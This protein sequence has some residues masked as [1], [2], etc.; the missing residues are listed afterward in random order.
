MSA[1]DQESVEAFA[2]RARAWLAEH[3]PRG[4]ASRVYHA[5]LSDEEVVAAIARGRELQRIL[6]DGGFAGICFPEGYGGLGLTPAH[7]Q[8]FTA[9]CAGYEMPL[10][11]N[12]PTFVPCG[13]ILVEFGTDEQKHRCLPA[14]LKGEALW[15]QFLSEPSGG[16]DVAGALTSAVRDGDEWV[17]NGSK[18]WTTGAWWSDYALCL[19]RT[20]WDVPKHRGLTVFIVEIRQPSVD[21]HRIQMIYGSRDFCQEFMTDLRVPDCDRVG[22]VDDG[23]T[24]CT[25]WMFHERNAVSGGSPYVSGGLASD[26]DDI[27]T[28]QLV[29][30]ARMTGRHDDAWT[31]DRIGEA[32]MLEHAHAALTRRIGEGLTD[33]AFPDAAA[34]IARLSSAVV[35]QRITT[36]GLELAGNAGAHSGYGMEYLMRQTASIGGGTSE[37]ARNNISE[38]VLGMPRE[39]TLDRETAFR[40]VPRG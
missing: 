8:V 29:A 1:S 10:F 25:R 3:M 18:I 2:L 27:Q 35:P 26:G 16:S 14:M 15:M 31:R 6:F 40:D 24:V 30:L 12:V 21:V 19:A 23:W 4:E 32:I 33:G 37:M 36:I 7:Q 28:K 22:D 39:L 34:A 38:R 17:L 13:A 9:E 5:G 11:I 20:N